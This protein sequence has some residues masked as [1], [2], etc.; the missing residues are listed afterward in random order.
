MDKDFKHGGKKIDSYR[1]RARLGGWLGLALQPISLLLIGSLNELEGMSAKAI[2]G[3][4]GLIS[5]FILMDW[6][7]WNY[8]KSKGYGNYVAALSIFCV[9]GLLILALLPD[10]SRN[11]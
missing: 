7:I 8:A 5:S 3:I 2:F 11:Q 1:K 10:K 4:S 9:Y 6:G